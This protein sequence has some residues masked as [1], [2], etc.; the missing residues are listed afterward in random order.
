MPSLLDGHPFQSSSMAI[1]DGLHKLPIK[2][3]VRR[4]VGK[5]TDDT[6]TAGPGRP[7]RRLIGT[8]T[9]VAWAQTAAR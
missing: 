2:A 4:A 6:F 5:E 1:R 9:Q 8:D 7:N 3:D